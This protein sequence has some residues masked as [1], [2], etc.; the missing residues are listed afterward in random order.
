MKN[1]PL[2][3]QLVTTKPEV[4]NQTSAPPVLAD[5]HTIEGSALRFGGFEL[6]HNGG[7]LRKAGVRVKLQAQPLKLLHLLA[8]HSGEIISRRDIQEYVWEP[9]THVDFDQGINACIKAIRSALGDRANAPRFIETVPRKGYRFV[10]PVEPIANRPKV[11]PSIDLEVETEIAKEVET[12]PE[13]TPVE[14]LSVDSDPTATPTPAQ[15][16][17]VPHR[18]TWTMAVA[19]GALVVL[20]FALLQWASTSEREP[21]AAPVASS[22]N[23]LAVLPFAL[24]NTDTQSHAYL[25]DAITAELITLLGRRY[26]NRLGVIARTSAMHYKNSDKP[27]PEIAGELDVAY[28]LE[29]TVR[30]SGDRLRVTAQLVDVSRQ[31]AVWAD[32]YDRS[33]DDLL[34][35]QAELA[36][37]IASALTIELLPQPNPE[38]A[39]SSSRVDSAAYQAYMQGRYHLSQAKPQSAARAIASL[40]RAVALDSR[41][42]PAYAALAQAHLD[43]PV[44]AAQR[45]PAARFAAQAALAIDPDNSEAHLALGHVQF[46]R[47]WNLDGARR[48]FDRAIEIAPGYAEA[49]HASAA[50]YSVTGQHELAIAAVARARML[51]PLS[52]S[53]NADVGWYSYFAG[54]YQ[55]AISHARATLEL[56]PDYYWAHRCILVSLVQQGDLPGAVAQAAREMRAKRADPSLLRQLDS[57]DPQAA[58][59]VYW[60]W[61]LQ[62][63]Q[64]LSDIRPVAPSGL[65]MIYL[66]LG[67]R[68]QALAAFEASADQRRGWIMPFLRVEPRVSS[69]R[70]EPRFQAVLRALDQPARPGPTNIGTT[71]AAGFDPAGSPDSVTN[72]CRLPAPELVRQ[73]GQSVLQMWHLPASHVLFQPMLPDDPGYL[74]YRAAVRADGADLRRPIADEPTADT[75]EQ[76]ASWARE[77]A[78]GE[79]VHSGRIGVIEPIQCLDALFFAY[80]HRRYSQ[81]ERPTE[82]LVSVLRKQVDGKTQLIAILGASDVMF[83]PKQFYGF[84]IVDDYLAQ[85][86]QFWYMLHN[87]TMQQRG[88]RLALG[89]P[90]PSINDVHLVRG[91]A[92]GR[93]LHSA[94]V[95]NG[96]YTSIIRAAEFERLYAAGDPD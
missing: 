2:Q 39:S 6:D 14:S 45:Y 90:V 5:S 62:R 8:S 21:H 79:L 66:A 12:E 4:M 67:E 26:R 96:L 25:G 86:W 27:L 91:L 24:I 3:F 52:P 32:S 47:D 17:R 53:V 70:A 54:R 85:G 1:K 7:E 59:E 60:R 83:P 48:S 94:R 56:E 18:R 75:P 41:F 72:R 13:V 42:A 84:D 43:H 88:E 77:R 30:H 73:E 38:S 58:L 87:H 29:G 49:H 9:G 37:T 46:Y 57:L 63:T 82:F 55:Q 23:R 65:A 16:L 10:A 68:E 33:L 20:A 36:E 78:N 40:E 34:A 80:Q 44:A 89:N 50:Y 22:H 61:D 74:A 81:I 51:D 11:E 28:L 35:V 15:W 76:Q 64:R 93:S 95:T 69:L 31:T 19:L 92:E 71:A